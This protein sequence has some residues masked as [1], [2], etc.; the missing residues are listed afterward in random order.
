MTD[1]KALASA[2]A[3]CDRPLN[4]NKA[5]EPH[6]HTLR[7]EAQTIVLDAARVHLASLQRKGETGGVDPAQAFDIG[8]EWANHLR[9]THF[10]DSRDVGRSL[11]SDLF[12]GI[13]L[14][15]DAVPSFDT[16][17]AGIAAAKAE[18]KRAL[19]ASPAPVEARG[20]SE[21][22]R[23]WLGAMN[24]ALF[25]INAPP[26]PSTD[27]V[28]HDRPDGPTINLPVY[29]LTDHDAKAIVDAH[30]AALESALSRGPG[31][32]VTGDE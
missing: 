32:M 18:I 28:W 1:E 9:N 13:H 26:R 22:H 27:D 19:S 12:D 7:H 14:D 6:E 21:G 10:A 30:N 8:F 2:I 23:W 5:L 25:I 11:C 3:E 24:D 16:R 15:L 29:G 17:A 20:V 4:L 31:R